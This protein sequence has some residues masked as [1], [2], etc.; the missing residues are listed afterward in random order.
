M[1]VPPGSDVVRVDPGVGEQLICAGEDV[2]RK[3]RVGRYLIHQLT[4]S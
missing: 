3:Y 2:E 1:C 4:G